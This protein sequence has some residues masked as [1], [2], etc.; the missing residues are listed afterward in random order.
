MDRQQIANALRQARHNS[1][2]TCKEVADHLGNTHKAVSAWEHC[3]GQPD[4]GALVRLC[5]IY[6]L[7]GVDELL[8]CFSNDFYYRPANR[9]SSDTTPLTKLQSEET[10]L[11]NVFRQLSTE[12][13]QI[14]QSVAIGLSQPA[15]AS[16]SEKVLSKEEIDTAISVAFGQKRDNFIKVIPQNKITDTSFTDNAAFERVAVP[17]I[18][19]GADFGIRI[20]DDSM[21]PVIN[22]GDIVIIERHAKVEFGDMGIFILNGKTLCRQLI[23]RDNTHYLYSINEKHKSIPIQNDSIYTLGRVLDKFSG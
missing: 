16:Q 21:H 11:L 3:N 23:Y 6:N 2:M 17:Y 8:G 20:E 9:P 5:K 15:S 4:I 18:P 1:N 19:P 12:N 13:K 14:V 22:E 10:E 7:S